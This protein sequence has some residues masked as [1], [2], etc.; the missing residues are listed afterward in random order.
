MRVAISGITLRSNELR[1]CV[2]DGS[3]VRG[4][5]QLFQVVK[6]GRAALPVVL[7]IGR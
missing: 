4:V 7:L 1:L 5:V 3:Q 6:L 2:N